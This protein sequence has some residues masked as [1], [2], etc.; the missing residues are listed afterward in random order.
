MQA[1]LVLDED[2]ILNS[3]SVTGSSTAAITIRYEQVLPVLPG[4]C[5]PAIILDVRHDCC[6]KEERYQLLESLVPGALVLM[7]SVPG[8]VRALAA[9]NETATPGPLCIPPD[10]LRHIGQKLANT[11]GR[12]DA[13][14]ENTP[15]RGKSE[16]MKEVHRLVSLVAP[17]DYQVMICGE[18]GTGKEVIAREIHERSHR[19]D[20]VFLTVDVGALSETLFESEMFGHRKGAFT[21]AKEDRT[22]R[23]EAAAGGTLLL[24]EIGNLPLSLQAKL[25][26]VLQSKKV[27][28]L[29]THEPIDLDVRIICATNGDLRAMVQ[30]GKFREDLLYRINTV[31]LTVPPLHDRPEDIPLLAE[32]FLK[33]F[34]TKYQKPYLKLSGEAISQ[35]LG[36]QWPGNIRELQHAMERAVIMGESETLQPDDFGS[37]QQSP[38]GEFRFDRLNLEQLEAWA[39]RK[40]IAK[41]QG[42]I[43]HAAEELGVS[44]GALY[45][46]METYGI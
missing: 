43:S 22:G 44:R 7:I 30:A 2:K 26:T 34:A 18:T 24:D 29:G 35:L 33:K 15:Y 28:R 8:D 12:T 46:R 19:A 3:R 31:E 16:S 25:L 9:I 40:V 20:G 17:T 10:L 37:P 32:H 5:P 38:A 14:D 1:I 6:E 42:N 21:D 23:F 39:I 36:Y 11:A 45:R 13:T 4:P 27:T 41:H